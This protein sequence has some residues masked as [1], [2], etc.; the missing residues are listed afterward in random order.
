MKSPNLEEDS[1]KFLWPSQDI[2]T[3][4]YFVAS[5]KVWRYELYKRKVNFS[6]TGKDT[7]QLKVR[8]EKYLI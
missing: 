4:L 2:L 3:L 5:K 6:A 7:F 1:A 8:M